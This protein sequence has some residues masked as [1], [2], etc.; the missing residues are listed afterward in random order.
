MAEWI[1]LGRPPYDLREH[2]IER[3][4][5]H[6]F[7][8]DYIRRRGSQNFREIYDILHPSQPLL[9]PRP[10]RITPFYQHQKDLGA[11]FLEVSGWERPH[12]YESNQHLDSAHA[13]ARDNWS[14]RFWSPIIAAEHKVAREKVALFDMTTLKKVEVAGPNAVKLLDKLTTGKMNM[15]TG[16]ISY[17][18]M[19]DE[20]GGIKS[21]IT[22]ARLG[23]E[24]FQLGLN[25]NV[26]IA[27]LKEHAA[28]NGQCLCTRHHLSL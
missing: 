13:P 15:R 18:L 19:L 12:W 3:F 20:S 2:H 24:L 8:P 11:F 21:D 10:L 25:N 9:E 1:A 7:S 17:T 27:Y 26:D 14:A 28:Q 16:N 6:G 5:K 22:V 23:A 4:E